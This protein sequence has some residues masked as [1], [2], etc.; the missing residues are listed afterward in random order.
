AAVQ[1]GA[2]FSGVAH[3]S[4]DVAATQ[5][6]QGFTTPFKRD[7]AHL[8]V[9]NACCLS[10]ESRLHP[11]L[12]TY[13]AAGAQHNLGGIG[14]EGLHERGKVFVGG[15]VTDDSYA[16]IAT[17]RCEPTDI[18]NVVAAKL[19]LRQVQQRAAGEGDDGVRVTRALSNDVVICHRP[20]AAGHVNGAHRLVENLG[21]RETIQGDTACQVEATAGLGRSNT[22]GLAG[23]LCLYGAQAGEAQHTCGHDGQSLLV[24]LHWMSSG[25]LSIGIFRCVR[26]PSKAFS[27]LSES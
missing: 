13:R 6:C 16:V 21:V 9:V 26:Y 22:F 2:R 1:H 27:I 25:F 18:I 11:V 14:L 8:L 4:L 17:Y 12:A 20:N 7:E 3:V 24:K 15:V 23:L 19:S 10:S 5:C